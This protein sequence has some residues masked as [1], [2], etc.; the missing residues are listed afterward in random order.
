MTTKNAL[1][2]RLRLEKQH[3]EI[4]I[5]SPLTSL[6]GMWELAV[7]GGDTTAYSGFWLMVDYLSERF[8]DV[9]SMTDLEP[10]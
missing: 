8:Q 2:V 7:E 1:A 4:A 5:S 6:S 3:P 9:E 10:S